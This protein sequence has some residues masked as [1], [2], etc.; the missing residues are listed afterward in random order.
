MNK[1]LYIFACDQFLHF[2]STSYCYIYFLIFLLLSLLLKFYSWEKIFSL[3]LQQWG[4]G[5]SCVEPRHSTFILKSLEL[6]LGGI[7][8]D[9]KTFISPMLIRRENI[10][11]VPYRSWLDACPAWVKNGDWQAS[12]PHT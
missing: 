3:Q 4:T 6:C 9:P 1:N 7:L 8:S 2:S 11:N 5:N 10:N 12:A